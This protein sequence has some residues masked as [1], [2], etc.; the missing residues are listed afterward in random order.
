MVVSITRS[1]GLTAEERNEVEGF[2]TSF[3][4]RLEREQPG[5]VA[6]YHF[7]NDE[8]NESTTII[9]W[10][11]EAAR[12]AYRE[13]ELIKEAIA[14]EQRLGLSSTR[15]AFPLTYPRE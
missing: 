12:L 6:A 3:L 14:T 11:D 10:Q 9:V 7:H 5:V 2:L 15:E 13:G 4:S 8:S 1:S